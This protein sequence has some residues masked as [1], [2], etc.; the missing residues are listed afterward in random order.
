[1][2]RISLSP[3]FIKETIQ[4]FRE[5][6]L[7]ELIFGKKVFFSAGEV[8]LM[9]WIKRHPSEFKK[10]GG[11]QGLFVKIDPIHKGNGTAYLLPNRLG[12]ETRES[13]L[14]FD[15]D[16]KITQG[17]DLWVYLSTND[18]VKKEGLGEFIDLGL[19]KGNKGGQS[20]VISST[21]ANLGHY[22]STVILCKQF[23]VLFSFATLT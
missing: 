5:K 6:S 4:L 17:P 12:D 14:V 7:K 3:K 16:V 21:I 8:G 22:R 18:N 23:S 9:E 2:P 19:I 11:R 20:Y 15:D 1:M 10:Q 13:I